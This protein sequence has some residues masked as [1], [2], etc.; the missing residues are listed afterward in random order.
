M[1]NRKLMRLLPWIV[2]AIIAAVLIFSKLTTGPDTTASGATNQQ[3]SSQAGNSQAVSNWATTIAESAL[4]AEAKQTLALIRKGGPYP[5]PQAD[6]K[7]F[8]NYEG[9]LP[10]KS[11]SYYLE[12][13]VKTPGR[14]G[15]EKRRIVTGQGG[16]KYYTADHYQSFRRILEGK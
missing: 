13:T 1:Q 3:R 15:R 6:N 7:R 10:Q 12:Y 2:V 14:T 9:V 8:G 11:S 16:E 5:Y 4:P